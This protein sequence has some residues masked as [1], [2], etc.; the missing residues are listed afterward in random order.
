MKAKREARKVM[1]ETEERKEL[2]EAL[3]KEQQQDRKV[4]QLEAMELHEGGTVALQEAILN[5]IEKKHVSEQEVGI[6]F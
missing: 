5:E 2:E 4:D 3:M 1:S 6:Y